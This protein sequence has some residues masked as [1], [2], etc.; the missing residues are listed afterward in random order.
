MKLNTLLL[1]S[2][3]TLIASSAFAADLPSKKAAPAAGSVQVCKVG[4]MTGFTVPGSDTCLGISGRVTVD[5]ANNNTD[6]DYTTDGHVLGNDGDVGFRLNFDARS[7]TELGSVRSFVRLTSTVGDGSG[8]NGTDV[9]KA[10]I[11]VAGFTV[12]LKDSLADIA[13]TQGNLFGN[14]WSQSAQGVDFQTSVGGMSLGIG[15]EDAISDDAERPDV[16]V[17]LGAK[18]GAMNFKVVGIATEDTNDDSGYTLLG[19]VDFTAGPAMIYAFAGYAT[20]HNAYIYGGPHGGY[21]NSDETTSLGGGVKF[22][23]ASATSLT[24]EGMMSDA[25]G[26]EAS[27]IGVYLSHALAKN[28]TIQPEVV[29]TDTDAHGD[30][31]GAMLRIQRDF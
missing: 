4:G 10:Y 30:W 15:L 5:F 20:G 27:K 13:G 24:V 14:Y 25:D 7:N 12:G 17:S 23:V 8:S 3:A 28:L 22:N 18:A 6:D 19:H 1:A 16:L 11:Q 21:S 31:T 9:D 29:F 2:A 26:S